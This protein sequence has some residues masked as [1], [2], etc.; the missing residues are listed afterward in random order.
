MNSTA[1]QL[2]TPDRK[3]VPESSD[4]GPPVLYF[5]GVCGLCS[6]AV[7]FVIRHDDR[8][9]FRF[10][11]LQGETAASQL[12]PNDVADLQS[13]LLVTEQGVYRRSAAVVRVLW[14]LGG[15]WWL[16]GWLL[17]IIPRPLRDVG[18]RLVARMRYRLFGKHE[19][20]RLPTP[21]ERE[22]FLP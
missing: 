12:S 10:A 14:L 16:L 20:C 11:P 4:A 3:I 1:T 8:G 15:I 6:R 18:Y 5:D 2:G 17:W 13:M 22:R 9:V 21:E 19:T 7:D